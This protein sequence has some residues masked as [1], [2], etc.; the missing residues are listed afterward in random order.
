MNTFSRALS[1]TPF[2]VLRNTLVGSEVVGLCVKEQPI[3][4]FHLVVP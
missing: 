3:R 1:F 2:G 4:F